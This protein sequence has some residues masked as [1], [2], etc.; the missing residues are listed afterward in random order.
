VIGTEKELTRPFLTRR[1]P[2]RKAKSCLFLDNKG[3]FYDRYLCAC[4]QFQGARRISEVVECLIEDIAWNENK[5]G[6]K[7]KKTAGVVKIIPIYY[8]KEIMS[9]LE[10]YLGHRKNEKGFVFLD[11]KNTE[12]HLKVSTLESYYRRTWKKLVSKRHSYN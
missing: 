8:P 7:L 9:S 6:F 5:I 3:Y 4:L 11:Q 12:S 1:S 2:V 10:E